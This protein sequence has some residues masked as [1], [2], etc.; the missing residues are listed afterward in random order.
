MERMANRRES[1]SKAAKESRHQIQA[2]V[3][4]AT[5]Q[6]DKTLQSW[7]HTSR[8]LRTRFQYRGTN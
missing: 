1:L 7:L 2:Q 6:R 3:A 4:L 8:Y 5:I